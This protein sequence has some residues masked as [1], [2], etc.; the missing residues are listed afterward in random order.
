MWLGDYYRIWTLAGHNYIGTELW[1]DHLNN[2][3]AVCSYTKLLPS[4]RYWIYLLWLMSAAYFQSVSDM[5][6]SYLQQYINY[7][8]DQKDYLVW[9]SLFNF[10]VSKIED[11][12]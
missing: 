2:E 6:I 12:K 10:C 1:C 11:S 3:P 8:K 7:G 9:Q 4:G 5:S